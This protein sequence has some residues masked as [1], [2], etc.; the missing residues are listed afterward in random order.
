MGLYLTRHFDSSV[1]EYM[2]IW[3]M[4]MKNRWVSYAIAL[5]GMMLAAT[6]AWA[7]PAFARQTGQACT[8]CHSAFPYLNLFGRTFKENGFRLDREQPNGKSV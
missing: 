5:L 2:K 7:L 6:D 1:E 8:Q 3:W 4:T